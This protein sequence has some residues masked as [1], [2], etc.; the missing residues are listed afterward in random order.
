[1]T[2]FFLLISSNE[3]WRVPIGEVVCNSTFCDSG[4]IDLPLP[5]YVGQPPFTSTLTLTGLPPAPLTHLR[6]QTFILY[7]FTKDLVITLVS[8]NGSTIILAS[9]QGLNRGDLYNGTIWD[10]SAAKSVASSKFVSGVVAPVLHPQGNLSSLAGQDP[11]ETGPWC[12]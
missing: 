7:P 4:W 11:M 5:K 8:P 10:D 9:G 2:L 6:I 1:M 3:H 12:R